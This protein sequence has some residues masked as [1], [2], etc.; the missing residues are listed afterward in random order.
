MSHDAVF[1]CYCILEAENLVEF[2]GVT[3]SEEEAKVWQKKMQRKYKAPK[4]TFRIDKL[5]LNQ[6]QE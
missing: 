3:T 4:N 2:G 6:I 1:V 5:V